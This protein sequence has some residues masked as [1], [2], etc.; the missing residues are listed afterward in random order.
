MLVMGASGCCGCSSCG[1]CRA[2]AAACAYIYIYIEGGTLS[3]CLIMCKLFA[4]VWRIVRE[5]GLRW[6]AAH[7]RYVRLYCAIRHLEGRTCARRRDVGDCV[8]VIAEDELATF[9]AKLSGT[10]G[11][12]QSCDGW[13]QQS[14]V[15]WK[16]VHVPTHFAENDAPRSSACCSFTRVGERSIKQ[17]IVH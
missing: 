6:T 4:K 13:L 17:S 15:K 12:S 2:A 8:G 3:S 7:I 11:S 14:K 5:C 9:A 1:G 10:T 16:F